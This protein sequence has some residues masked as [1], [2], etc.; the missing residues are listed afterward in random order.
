MKGGVV[1]SGDD[2]YADIKLARTDV[3]E[4]KKLRELAQDEASIF[5][6]VSNGVMLDMNGLASVE[7]QANNA[8]P[9]STNG[10]TADSVAPV[11]LGC[12]MDMSTGV[13]SLTFDETIDSGA[14]SYTKIGFQIDSAVYFLSAGTVLTTDDTVL[15]IHLDNVD[16]N[17]L[18]FNS[19]HTISAATTVVTLI[20]GAVV[21]VQAGTANPV[22]TT[23]H[24]ATAF[25]QD[26]VRPELITFAV[27]MDEKKITFNFNEVIDVSKIDFT[28]LQLQASDY[29][30]SDTTIYKPTHSAAQ[31]VNSAQVEVF[32]EP[33]DLNS[34][35]NMPALYTVNTD[36][37]LSMYEEPIPISNPSFESPGV[38]Y[39][40]T[41]S[42]VF[43]AGVNVLRNVGNGGTSI[44]YTET[45]D[46][47]SFSFV[48]PTSSMSQTINGELLQAGSYQIRAWV[49]ADSTL[50]ESTA[51]IEFGL[52]AGSDTIDSISFKYSRRG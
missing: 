38:E 47:D 4:I 11:Y 24:T 25:E 8:L 37:W 17:V 49:L 16:L 2:T 23:V 31:T 36:T 45:T 22:G 20:V 14:V 35:K 32:F 18:K 6:S 1:I 48:T 40:A 26:L 5:L 43:S 44:Q 12:N 33:V 52:V 39:A 13:L 41:D 46:G 42:W 10:F 27:N 34:I 15:E 9:I 19:A 30:T 29:S 3:N 7:R 51:T 50:P 21:D 28:A